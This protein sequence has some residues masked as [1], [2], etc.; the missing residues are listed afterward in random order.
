MLVETLAGRLGRFPNVNSVI[1]QIEQSVSALGNGEGKAA[2]VAVYALWHNTTV[3][4]H[5]RPAAADL[6]RRYGRV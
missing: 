6:L 4:E 2:M 3:A 5:H 1:E